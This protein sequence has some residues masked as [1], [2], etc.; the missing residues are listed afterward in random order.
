MFIFVRS[1][2]PNVGWPDRVSYSDDYRKRVLGSDQHCCR[3]PTYSEP[4]KREKKASCYNQLTRF[5][6]RSCHGSMLLEGC[7]VTTP[8]AFILICE[9]VL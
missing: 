2:F 8:G 3:K 7:K 6:L 1:L 9:A 4:R 5:S